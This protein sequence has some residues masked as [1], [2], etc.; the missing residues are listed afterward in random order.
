MARHYPAVF[1][2]KE[3]SVTQASPAQ[4]T[5]YTILD[6]AMDIRIYAITVKV[7]TTGETLQCRL[8]IDGNTWWDQDITGTANTNYW[9]YKDNDPSAASDMKE[10]A[11]YVAPAYQNPLDGHSVKVEVRKT[12][13]NGSG[14]LLGRVTY[15]VLT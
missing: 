9:E 4:N 15:G 14:N 7:S 3:A 5:W 10:S 6:T 13:A 11:T 1:I 12:T 2:A 8:T